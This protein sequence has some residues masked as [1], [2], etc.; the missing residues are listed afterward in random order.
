MSTTAVQGFLAKVAEDPELQAEMTKAMDADNDRDAVTALANS[1]GYD[2]STEEL[3]AEVQ[4][5]QAAAAKREEAGELSDEELQAVAGGEVI[6]A[7][8]LA[9]AVGAGAAIASYLKTKW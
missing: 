9:T 5:R 3:W 6:V 4:T 1:K 7:T 8:A 2:F